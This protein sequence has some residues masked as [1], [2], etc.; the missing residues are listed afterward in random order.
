[1]KLTSFEHLRRPAT[2][3]NQKVHPNGDLQELHTFKNYNLLYII[4]D[5]CSRGFLIQRTQFE[6]QDSDG[7]SALRVQLG[8]L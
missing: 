1:M 7:Q 4:Y 2:K 3:K 6:V 5:P 8:R